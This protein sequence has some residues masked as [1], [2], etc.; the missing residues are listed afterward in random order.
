[1][2]LNITLHQQIYKKRE[3]RVPQ[4]FT[5]GNCAMALPIETDLQISSA[6]KD[7]MECYF[8]P[9]VTDTHTP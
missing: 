4:L 2:S 3:G 1:M 9:V 6:V 7:T 8:V 5:F